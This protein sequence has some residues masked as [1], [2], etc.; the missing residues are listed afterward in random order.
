VQNKNRRDNSRRFSNPGIVCRGAANVALIITEQGLS[1]TFLNHLPIR[2]HKPK[3]ANRVKPQLAMEDFTG[4]VLGAATNRCPVLTGE[5]RFLHLEF[6]G[7]A[8]VPPSLIAFDLFVPRRNKRNCLV[9]A[10]F[11][12]SILGSMSLQDRRKFHFLLFPKIGGLCGVS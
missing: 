1:L 4:L 12:Y 10:L 2:I 11:A 5:T 6:R 3:A 8:T 9:V 7:H